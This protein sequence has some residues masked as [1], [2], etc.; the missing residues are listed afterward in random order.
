MR[1]PEQYL[2]LRPRYFLFFWSPD[3]FPGFSDCLPSGYFPGAERG[4]DSCI[5]KLYRRLS[6]RFEPVYE[7]KL[8]IVFDL[9]SKRTATLR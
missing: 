1:R 6:S 9:H 4:G 2:G 5:A 7:N 3:L 8:V